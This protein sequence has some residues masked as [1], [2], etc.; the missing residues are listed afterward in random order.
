MKTNI[1]MAIYILGL[2]TSDFPVPVE[3]TMTTNGL[4]GGLKTDIVVDRRL[5]SEMKCRNGL[6]HIMENSNVDTCLGSV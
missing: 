4:D 6:I 5:E 1:K 3:P 2:L